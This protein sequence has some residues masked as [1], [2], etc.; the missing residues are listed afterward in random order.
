MTPVSDSSG[1]IYVHGCSCPQGIFKDL[2][3]GKI[4]SESERPAW[5][6]QP[7]IQSPLTLLAGEVLVRPLLWETWPL[8]SHS[9]FEHSCPFCV[10]VIAA[11]PR[12]AVLLALASLSSQ[13]LPSW[14]P[15]PWLLMAVSLPDQFGNLFGFLL[16]LLTSEVC[17]SVASLTP[18]RP[19]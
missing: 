5:L 4:R 3:R 15:D 6:H 14:P 17:G 11:F 18:W 1:V 8:P 13:L 9:S 10:K 2:I 16:C 12:P 7:S 19:C